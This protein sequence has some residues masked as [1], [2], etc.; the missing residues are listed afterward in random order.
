M[1]FYK[2]VLYEPEHDKTNKIACAPS[3]D[4]DQPVYLHSLSR[5]FDVHSKDSDQA[6]RMPRLIFAGCIGDFVGF[7]MLRL[8]WFQSYVPLQ[9]YIPPFG[10]LKNQI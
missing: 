9:F 6:G 1:K 4:S 10:T 5:V 7:V 3:A 2:Y 8:I